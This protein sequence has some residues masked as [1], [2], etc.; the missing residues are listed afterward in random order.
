MKQAHKSIRGVKDLK[1]HSENMKLCGQDLGIDLPELSEGEKFNKGT[2]I[3]S[4][5]ETKMADLKKCVMEKAGLIDASG[6]LI[7]STFKERVQSAFADDNNLLNV[8]VEAVDT[9]PEPQELKMMDFFNC[10]GEACINNITL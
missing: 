2:L 10:M 6:L 9:C 8:M 4:L 7:R 5:T 1:T 3:G